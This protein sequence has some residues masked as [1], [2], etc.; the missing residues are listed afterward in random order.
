MFLSYIVFLI[1]LIIVVYLWGST[2]K[3]ILYS[4]SLRDVE[5]T[6]A[7]VSENLVKTQG[8]PEMWN[9]TNVKVFGLANGSRSLSREK[10]LN[11]VDMMSDS[12]S[13]NNCGGNVT[14]YECN[15]HMTGI[16][17]YDIYF[18][19]EYLNGSTVNINGQTMKTGKQPAGEENK[20]SM[21][22]TSLLNETIVHVKVVVW[23]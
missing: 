12:A 17:V 1:V 6:A 8:A 14:N 21:I 22:R 23:R 5:D 11:F 15:R 7:S 20:V 18:T 3:D 9:K 2:V 4:E 10:L 19:L 16:G 13:S